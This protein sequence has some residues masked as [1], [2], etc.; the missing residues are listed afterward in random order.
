MVFASLTASK[1]SCVCWPFAFAH[2]SMASAYPFFCSVSSVHLDGLQDFFTYSL[3]NILQ[4]YHSSTD[5]MTFCHSNVLFN[6]ESNLP[7][8][9]FMPST[10][11]VLLDGWVF[12]F[13]GSQRQRNSLSFCSQ[14][15]LYSELFAGAHTCTPP[16]PGPAA[17]QL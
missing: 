8:S 14:N 6:K 17:I 11:Q 4:V 13:S 9:L 2:L 7:D 10:S 5:I 3:H 15:P 12:F 16:P 1:L